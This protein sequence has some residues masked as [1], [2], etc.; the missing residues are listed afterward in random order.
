MNS[1]LAAG[2]E[3]GGMFT[4]ILIGTWWAD[5]PHR[6]PPP[7]GLVEGNVKT[8]LQ[9]GDYILTMPPSSDQ[10]RGRLLLEAQAIAAHEWP[11]VWDDALRSEISA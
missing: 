9:P 4:L 10:Q 11:R 1:L 6:T 8:V 2:F 3:W 5:K 7:G